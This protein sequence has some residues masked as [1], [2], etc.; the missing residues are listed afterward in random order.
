[1]MQV[2]TT[3]K[4][5]AGTK[6]RRPVGNRSPVR[7]LTG[8]AVLL[9][10][11]SQGALARLQFGKPF[12]RGKERTH[13]TDVLLQGWGER[14]RSWIGWKSEFY[15]LKTTGE[16]EVYKSYN[17]DSLKQD[18]KLKGGNVSKGTKEDE[19]TLTVESDEELRL[20]FRQ[21]NHSGREGGFYEA[22]KWETAFRKFQN[23]KL[24]GQGERYT[25]KNAWINNGKTKKEFYELC[26]ERNELK[27][28]AFDSYVEYLESYIEEDVKP[29]QTWELSDE[30]ELVDDTNLKVTLK[31]G[32]SL[33]LR[34]SRPRCVECTGTGKVWNRFLLGRS[35]CDKCNGTGFRINNT[36]HQNLFKGVLIW[37]LAISG[38]ADGESDSGINGEVAAAVV[39]AYEEAAREVTRRR[40]LLRL[41][42][43]EQRRRA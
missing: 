36:I 25:Q 15:V 35:T 24:F 1:M 10:F 23:R 22:A 21:A 43:C 4:V 31:N 14:K 19:F 38:E 8:L 29:K 12:G 16:L 41:L 42:T 13:S 6:Y 40:R 33:H 11:S 20:R 39:A 2:S 30:V 32:E 26:G 17:P 3:L 37:Q 28:N 34:F 7:W 9:A 27:L 5:L 18:F